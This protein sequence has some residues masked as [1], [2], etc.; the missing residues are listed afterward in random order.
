M[1][2]SIHL[3]NVIEDALDI[4][5][6]EN[7]NFHIFKEMFDIRLAVKEVCDIMRFQVEEKG[8]TLKMEISDSVPIKINSDLKRIKQV[9]FNLFG[10]AV[11]FTFVGE[12]KIKLF[13]DNTTNILTGIVS[14]TGL[15]IQ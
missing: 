5:R 15:G 8:L 7:S 9:L 14:D 12:I 13:F 6:L 2:S 1:N 3:Q 11:K 4:S 10:N